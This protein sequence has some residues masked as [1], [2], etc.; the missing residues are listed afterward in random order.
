MNVPEG[1]VELYGV[2]L[3]V[4]LVAK[5]VPFFQKPVEI[6]CIGFIWEVSLF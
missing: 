6:L 1:L 2:L 3:G 4:C 5:L